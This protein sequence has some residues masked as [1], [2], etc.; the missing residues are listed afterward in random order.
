MELAGGFADCAVAPTLGGG[1]DFG[2]L[3][4]SLVCDD[5][6]LLGDRLAKDSTKLGEPGGVMACTTLSS[7]TPCC[8]FGSLLFEVE[9]AVSVEA[10][11]VREGGEVTDLGEEW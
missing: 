11:L 2:R 5:D 3:L 4:G 7:L 10:L 9:P 6:T 8:D 1:D